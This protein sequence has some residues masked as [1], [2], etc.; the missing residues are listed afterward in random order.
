MATK[1]LYH[2]IKPGTDC[3]DGIAAAWVARRAYKPISLDLQV[4][5]VCYD[6]ELPSVE[7]GDAIVIVDF[8]YPLAVIQE[9]ES[10][11]CV[12]RVFDHHKT[13][14][15]NLS[16]FTGAVFDMAESG[17]TLTWREM[18]SPP[19]PV[20]LSYIKDRDLWE[21]KLPHSKEINEAIATIRYG[22][23][24]AVRDEAIA[25]ELIFAW[26]DQLAGMTEEQLIDYLLP[27][28]EPIIR[29][30][31]EQVEAIAAR[32]QWQI[33]K[34]P[35]LEPKSPIDEEMLEI[36]QIVVVKLA[37]DGSEDRLISDI[38][39]VLYKRFPQAA[40]A[41]CINSLGDWSLR[42]DKDGNNTDVAAI[43]QLFGGGG[44]R[45]AAGFKNP[46]KREEAT[47]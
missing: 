32:C 19:M 43:A 37:E 11:G 20:F 12:I 5:G 3:P 2:Q 45:N 17:A 38:C 10:R 16:G 4:I 31:M 8:S 33:F 14:L 13:A 22:I 9:W 26:F 27:I 39:S 46:G 36:L 30:K 28:G 15:D 25:R 41:A 34:H 35:V 42:S 40:F 21:W 29:K 23:R 7:S 47:A 6:G 44:H 18:F 1:I 24:S